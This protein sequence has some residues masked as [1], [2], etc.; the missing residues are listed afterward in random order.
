MPPVIEEGLCTRCGICAEICPEDVFYNSQKA[1]LPE[2][3][4]PYECYHCAACVIDCPAQAIRLYI[5][6]PMRL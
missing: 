3:T 5:P 2:V 4:H 6:F 1:E